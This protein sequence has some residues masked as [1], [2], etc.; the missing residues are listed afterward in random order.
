MQMASSSHPKQAVFQEESETRCWNSVGNVTQL[1][2][3][4]V[5]FWRLKHDIRPVDVKPHAFQNHLKSL[6]EVL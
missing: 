2:P 1:L 5:V 6:T 3:L 4:P